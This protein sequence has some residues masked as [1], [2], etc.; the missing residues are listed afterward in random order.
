MILIILLFFI[1]LILLYK[2]YYKTCE[3]IE[4]T[5]YD[6]DTNNKIHII[7]YAFIFQDR[8]TYIVIPQLNDLIN[9]QLLNISNLT[10]VLCGD[11]KNI[12]NCKN[13]L[14]ELFEANNISNYNIIYSYNNLFEYAGINELYKQGN[15][16]PDKILLYFHSKGMIF[17]NNNDKQRNSDEKKLFEIVIKDWKNILPIFDNN[18]N[19]NK[20]SVGCSEQ[21][22]CWYNFFWI[23]GSYL[24]NCNPPKI[25]NDRYYYEHYIG[26]EYNI[27]NDL[28]YSD[29]YNLFDNNKIKFYDSYTISMIKISN[30][31]LLY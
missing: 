15:I 19:I 31:T 22:F 24:V 14:T 7:Y 6:F 8:W 10:I 2:Y 29:C 5:Q 30:Y 12:Y 11:K 17:S 4:N 26:I 25:S 13:I 16:Y 1:L 21:G 28:P 18:Q 9:T 3:K 27:K 20:V 23:R